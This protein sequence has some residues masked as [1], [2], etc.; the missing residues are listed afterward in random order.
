VEVD[1]AERADS[2]AP[3]AIDSLRLVTVG[4]HGRIGALA[5]ASLV[6]EDLAL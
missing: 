2:S 1:R 4:E 3:A 6:R 5:R